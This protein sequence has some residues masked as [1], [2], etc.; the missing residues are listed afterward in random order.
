M[1]ELKFNDNY[2]ESMQS[3]LASGELDQFKRN[4]PKV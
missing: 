2:N 3:K 4:P 1:V